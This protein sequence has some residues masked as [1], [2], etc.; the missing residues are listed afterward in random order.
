MDCHTPHVCL[1]TLNNN[2]VAGQSAASPA[3][4]EQFC[5]EQTN[6]LKRIP[7]VKERCKL[8]WMVTDF[9]KGF[10]KLMNVNGFAQE[11]R[12]S[13]SSR[14]KVYYVGLQ[15]KKYLW[16]TQIRFYLYKIFP[17]VEISHATSFK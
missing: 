7:L 8:K 1:I 4:V 13:I 9:S 11:T 16:P 12:V 2:D 17:Q 14:E 5:L 6:V 3:V 15:C 10:G